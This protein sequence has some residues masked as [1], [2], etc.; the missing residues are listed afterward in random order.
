MY[1]AP[2]AATVIS[3]EKSTV[4]VLNR[5]AFRHIVQ[6]IGAGKLRQYISFM[7][8]VELLRP[9]ASYEREQLAD[10]LEAVTFNENELVFE[11]GDDGYAMYLVWSGNFEVRKKDNDSLGNGEIVAKVKKGDY[12]GER[13]LMKKEPRAATVIATT[14]SICLKLDRSAFD[15]LL[16][17]LE[18]L[19]KD[20]YKVMKKMV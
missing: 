5:H 9:L 7:N 6:D 19:L 17:P 12:F 3:T 4:W 2:R 18:D 14:K 15:L 1:N 16:G 13:A 20:V 10:A 11:Q 8:E